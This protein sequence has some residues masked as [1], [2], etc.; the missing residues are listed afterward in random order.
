M[1]SFCCKKVLNLKSYLETTSYLVN[2]AP[3]LETNFNDSN[4][5]GHSFFSIGN[6]VSKNVI[7]VPYIACWIEITIQL[8]NNR[9]V[10]IFKTKI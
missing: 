6:F 8:V 4:A 9:I 5:R 7:K 3:C 1:F 2:L 10:F